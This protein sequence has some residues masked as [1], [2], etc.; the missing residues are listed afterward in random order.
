MKLLKLLVGIIYLLPLAAISQAEITAVATNATC[1]GDGRADGTIKIT[2]KNV[3]EPTVYAVAKSPYDPA[4]VIASSNSLITH[5][6]PG[7]YFY[8]YYQ[9]TTFIRAATTINIGSTFNPISPSIIVFEGNNYTYC[10][11]N[12]DPLG[13]ITIIA[14]KGNPPYTISLLKASDNSVVRTEKNSGGIVY[15]YGVPSG[16]YKALAVDNCG[17][18]VAPSAIVDL[19]PNVT[20]NNFT[21]DRGSIQ[22]VDITYNIPGNACSGISSATLPNGLLTVCSYVYGAHFNGSPTFYGT[23]NF[24]YKLE[25]QNGSGWD[26]YDNLTLDQARGRYPLP[27]DRSKWG[28]VRISATYCN[29][30]KTIELDYGASTIGK[31]R[32]FDTFQASI[33]DDPANTNCTKSGQVVLKNSGIDMGGCLPYKVEVTENGTAVTNTYTITAINKLPICLLDI[34]KSYTVKVID[35]EGDEAANYAFKNNTTSISAVKPDIKD[36]KN[37]FIDKNF[38]W[39][40][41]YDLKNKIQFHAGPSGKFFGKCALAVELPTAGFEGN[42]TVSLISGPSTLEIKK[43]GSVIGL[44]I[45]LLPGAYKIR[46]KDSGCFDEE[47]EIVLDSY[48]TKIAITKV[49]YTSSTTICDRY[50]KN[51]TVEISAVGAG[52]I[53]STL[54]KFYGADYIFAGTITAP[55]GAKSFSVIPDN[56]SLKK[57]TIQYSFP[58]ELSGKY[59]LGISRKY[60]GNQ[61]MSK[62]DIFETSEVVALDVIPNFPVFDLSKSGGIVCSGNTTGDI[63]VKVDNVTESVTYFI[64][65]ET[66]ANF[67]TT[68]Q[69]SPIF[70]NLTAGNYIVKAKTACYEVLQPVTLRSSFSKLI[71]GN[72]AVCEGE[73]I[74]LALI[75]IGPLTSVKWTLP[76]GS[77]INATELNINNA[78]TAQSGIYKVEVNSAGGCY[79]TDTITVTVGG[80]IT[81]TGNKAQQFCK[82]SNPT[83][84]NLSTTETGVVWYD[85]AAAGNILPAST[86]LEDGKTYFGALPAVGACTGGGARLAVT[87]SIN[88][89]KTPTGTATQEFCAAAKATVSNLVTTGTNVVWYDAET[90]GNIIPATTALIDGKTYYGA[91]K[92]GSCESVSRLAVR[93]A[94]TDPKTPT[95]TSIQEFCTAVKAT[96]SN[97]VSTG[98]NVVWYDAATLGNIIPSTTALI[99][100]KIYYGAQKSGSC[101]SILRLAVTVSIVD[102]KTPTGTSTQEFCTAVKATVSN[103]VSTGTN[104]VWY[105]APTLGNIIPSTTAL[106]DGKIY[107]GAQKSGSCES[108]LRLAV[109]VSIVDPKTPTGTATQEFCTT[110]KAT[111]SD[112]ATTGIN[113]VW[114]DAPTLGNIIPPTTALIDGKIYYGAQKSGTCESGSRLAVKAVLKNDTVDKLNWNAIACV[115]EKVTYKTVAGMS[116]YKWNVSGE[117]TITAGGQQSDDFATVLWNNIGKG[118]IEVT[119]TDPSKCTPMVAINFP[120]D[121]QSCLSGDIELKKVV[122]NSITVIGQNVVFTISAGNLG[123]NDFYNVEISEMLPLGYDYIKSEV[124]SGDYNPTTGIWNIPMLSANKTENLVITAKVKAT[125][126]HLN[127]AYLKTSDPMDSN[128]HNNKAEAGIKIPEVVVYNVVSP[129]GDGLNDYLKI[130]GLEQFSNNSIEIYNSWGTKVFG[131]SNYGANNNFFH[132]TSEGGNMMINKNVGLPPGTYF[133]VLSYGNKGLMLEK[134][135]YIYL[136]F[137]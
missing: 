30:T 65:K 55:A 106:I 88:D 124:S 135:G 67:P 31:R 42:V 66:D 79:F 63:Y 5:L 27:S 95:G 70:K 50:V 46:V 102:P 22:N 84:A 3:S 8:G 53:D 83:V 2:V 99:D 37:I 40:A 11:S 77:Q 78:T 47:Y 122:N 60:I 96:V 21:F 103:L 85:A 14:Q 41:D 33:E 112:L 28:L 7:D 80:G 64:K 120:V 93:V 127:V 111:V 105:D 94:I 97:L 90:L 119:Y 48:F 117:G 69:P 39:P 118:S 129:N 44:G 114:Y 101:E 133:Y 62:N 49:D 10:P 136:T 26:V 75:H 91:Q 82:G 56:S 32:P 137:R 18:V 123:G 73:N 59:E 86:I 134:S 24:V 100:G 54:F 12:P 104:V 130:D 61:L 25:I 51:I 71:D 15:F 17:T 92:S 35:S 76:D 81:P 58:L 113:V 9:G 121:V 115:F 34:D 20:F 107:Y 6:E 13:Q 131:T 132:G 23:P 74:K 89:P 116:S 110:A 52:I 108:V 87:V 128:P 68:G 36:P 45:Q 43:S 16:S 38:F 126:D 19:K 1:V 98:T 57:G 29:V 72:T 109:T 4:N 125:G